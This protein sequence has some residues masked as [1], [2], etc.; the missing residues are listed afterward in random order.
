MMS[1]TQGNSIFIAPSE[2]NIQEPWMIFMLVIEIDALSVR[3]AMNWRCLCLWQVC[4]H[5]GPCSNR[6]RAEMQDKLSFPSHLTGWFKK[7]NSKEK[8]QNSSGT[9][10]TL[11][12]QL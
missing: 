8:V 6:S 10:E 4:P 5:V 12:V 9:F 2:Q 7:P 1:E 3:E 11:E